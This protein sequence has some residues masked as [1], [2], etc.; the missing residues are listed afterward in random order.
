MLVV[1]RHGESAGNAAGLLLGRLE[2][3]LTAR[4][5]EQ[6]RRVAEVLGPVRRIVTSPLGRARQTAAAFGDGAA[7]EIDERW[8]E[9]DYGEFDG[10]P[11]GTVPAEV[12]RRWRAD[13]AYRPPGGE[14]LAEV[15]RRVRAACEELF[16]ADGE[17]ARG[18]EDVVVVS[19]VSPIKAAVAWALGAGD[20]VAWRL[21]LAPGS[22]TRIAWGTDAPVLQR[23]NEVPPLTDALFSDEVPPSDPSTGAVTPA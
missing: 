23:Y 10:T 1:V 9:V 14:S 20:E 11:L 2:S 22:I 16:G 6:A 13:P 4:G 21:Y 18:D 17:G 19:H 12:W 7:V 8:I 5:E 15:G 3:A